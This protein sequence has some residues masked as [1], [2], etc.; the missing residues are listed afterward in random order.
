M[1]S[2]ACKYNGQCSNTLPPRTF[3]NLSGLTLILLPTTAQ[4]IRPDRQ[5]NDGTS[6]NNLPFLGNRKNA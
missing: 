6:D 2:L 1:N 5:N 4:N 3:A